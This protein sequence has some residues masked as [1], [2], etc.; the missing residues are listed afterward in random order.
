MAGC[1]H[2]HCPGSIHNPP[3]QWLV[4]AIVGLTGVNFDN[5]PHPNSLMMKEE[6]EG[7]SGVVGA[8]PGGP[9]M[10][11][12]LHHACNYIKSIQEVGSPASA[13]VQHRAYTPRLLRRTLLCRGMPQKGRRTI[14]R[15]ENSFVQ[16][17]GPNDAVCLSWSMEIQPLPFS[18]K[19]A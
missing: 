10:T 19:L 13:L 3:R 6:E 7:K 5:M 1:W 4:S 15:S 11:T 12:G 17:Q 2:A 18:T 9:W 8:S 14:R 16:Q